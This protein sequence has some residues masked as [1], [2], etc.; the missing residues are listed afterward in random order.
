MTDFEREERAFSE[1]LRVQAESESFPPLDPA[2]FRG[3]R[4]RTHRWPVLAAAAS[5]VV[6][7]AAMLPSLLLGPLG[8]TTGSAPGTATGDQ[9]GMRAEPAGGPAAESAPA[10]EAVPSP[11]AGT[12][13]ES[14]RDV[15]VQ[16][17]QEWGYAVDPDATW[18]AVPDAVPD[19][20]YVDTGRGLGQV[21][22]PA[23]DCLG[24]LP[25][26]RQKM[27][28]GFSLVGRPGPSEVAEGW[29]R[30]ERTL[31]GV[32]LWVVA[33]ATRAGLAEKILASARQAPLGIDHNAC[34]VVRADAPASPLAGVVS[35]SVSVCLYDNSDHG[36]VASTTLTGSQANAAWE[37]ILAA[38]AGG[39]PNGTR[40]ECGV[41][42]AGPVTIVLGFGGGSRAVLTFAGCTGNGLSDSGVDKGLRRVT[43]DLCRA[44]IVPPVAVF[45]GVGPAAAICLGATRI[46]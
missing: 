14:F 31:G 21:A 24:P 13:W 3:A 32:R 35:K 1:G 17:P 40:A 8:G 7:A 11:A 20:P 33:P 43:A 16:V 27:H 46:P 25:A 30:Y 5:V 45:S 38:P 6:I 36:L 26:G 10:S 2:A 41:D 29:R 4:A 22:V 34:P 12:R 42:D 44:V 9:A 18:C 15:M 28:L 23:V 39:G 37:A 19:A